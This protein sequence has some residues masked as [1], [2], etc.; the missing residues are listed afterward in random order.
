MYKLQH[1]YC[2]MVVDTVTVSFFVGIDVLIIQY[3]IGQE[4]LSSEIVLTFL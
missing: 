1:S 2:Y 3:H 4:N